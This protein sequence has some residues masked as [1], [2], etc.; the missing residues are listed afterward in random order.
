MFQTPGDP[1]SSNSVGKSAT[2]DAKRRWSS[3]WVGMGRASESA[4]KRMK[5]SIRKMTSHLYEHVQVA[6][7]A[8]ITC[9]ITFSLLKP[10][11]R[12]A[13]TTSSRLAMH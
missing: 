9:N 11:F 6:P 12:I 8:C 1:H 13:E 4:K 3:I 10:R 2:Q 7:K 5:D